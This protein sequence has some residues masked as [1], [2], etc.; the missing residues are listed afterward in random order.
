[1]LIRDGEAVQNIVKGGRTDGRTDGGTDSRT[2]GRTE[3]QTAGRKDGRTDGRPDGPTDGL[4]GVTWSDAGCCE[5]MRRNVRWYDAVQ[6]GFVC[7]MIVKVLLYIYIYIYMYIYI[8]NSKIYEA[9]GAT[10]N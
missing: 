8:L 3:E 7:G 5:L 1:M 10:P 9:D 2:E 6:S 4:Y